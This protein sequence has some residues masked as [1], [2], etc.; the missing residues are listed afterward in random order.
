MAADRLTSL[1]ASFLDVETASAH[2][3]VGW[4]A[5]FAPPR[6]GPSPSFEQLRD[7]IARRLKRAPR[8]RQRLA[9]VPLGVHRPVWVDD[10]EFDIDRHV[11]RAPNGDLDELTDSVMSTPL[12]RDRPL[13]EL[14]IADGLDD[15]G[16]AVVGKA[17][18][19]MVD[20]I[21]A[22]EL[23]A[24][25]LDAEPEVPADE[26]EVWAPA[27]APGTARRLVRGVVDRLTD[28]FDVLAAPARVAASPRRAGEFVSRAGQA[29]ISSLAPTVPARVLNDP[30]SPYRRLARLRRPLADLKLVKRAFGTKLNDVVLAVSAGALAGYLAER[31][32]EPRRLKT[33]VPV[34]VRGEDGAEQLGNRISFLFLELPCDEPDPVRRLREVHGATQERKQRGEPEGSEAML[35]VMSHAPS[36]LQ[37]VLSRLVASPRTFNLVVSNIPGPPVPLYML[38]CELIDAY[39]VVPLADRHTLSIGFT[40]VAGRACFGLYA[41]RDALPDADALAVHLDV[42]IEELIELSREREPARA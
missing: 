42:A 13:W 5:S 26:P 37:R 2:M 32:E 19:C 12:A 28:E 10:D 8:Y 11:R 24:L 15:G 4:V 30:L 40:T 7:H 9:G 27:P 39:P 14:W 22:V 34:N 21:A 29:L 25:L 6:S 3:H 36:T 18:H 38:G 35:D 33:M 41:D 31:G 1:D 20:G 17:H 16:L 23:G